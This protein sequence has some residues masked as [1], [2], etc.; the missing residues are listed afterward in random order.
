MGSGTSLTAPYKNQEVP[1]TWLALIDCESFYASCEA[2]FDPQLQ[3]KPIVVLSNNDGCVVALNRLAKQ[4]GIVMG[5]PWFQ[6]SAWAQLSGIYA[7]SSNYEL[8]GS[9]S[10]RVMQIIGKFAAKQEI[11]SVDECFVEL[12]GTVEET[13][14]LGKKIRETV[15]QYTGVPV[16]VAIATTKTLAKIASIGAKAN[17]A[18]DG[19]CHLYAYTADQREK[20]LQAIT[21][22][23]IWGVGRRLTKK[24]AGLNIHSAAALRDSNVRVMRK[25][26]GVT[27]ARTIM[28][29]RGI[30]CITLEQ[31]PH[32][33]QDQ[34]IY[35]RSFNKPIQ[36]TKEMQHVL[37]VYAQKA[38]ARMR[39]HGLV[40]GQVSAWAATAYHKERY[41]SVH[42]SIA[43]P[44][45]S[46]NPILLGKAAYALLSRM[47][48]RAA[49]VRAGIVL[50]NLAAKNTNI[51]LDPFDPPA[52]H[53][54][55]G[56]T[57]DQIVTKHGP[58]SIG[59][60]LGGMRSAPSWNMRRNMLSKRATT[61]WEEVPIVL[62]K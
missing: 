14:N 3:G 6:I 40:A 34:L 5:T 54:H 23:E 29:L 2:V 37:S 26:F 12:H 50:T 8:Y 24:L 47:N 45:H 10:A 19:V 41:E 49:Y 57:I 9:M 20:I 55:I 56:Q 59:I 58:K 60:G 7:R 15:L 36:S 46:D 1:D 62:A 16:R 4:R 33:H 25:K 52:S 43:L 11:Y 48:P 61:V 21:T 18:L 31:Q 39:S 32:E 27:M 13:I 53:R 38:G 30:S 17:L 28:E 51:P 44:C 22:H 35:S 42:T